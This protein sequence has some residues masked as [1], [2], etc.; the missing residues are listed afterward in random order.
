MLEDRV[1]AASYQNQTNKLLI[2][3]VSNPQLWV[4]KVLCP[5]QTVCFQVNRS[6]RIEIYT[7]SLVT[8]MIE[9]I[10]LAEELPQVVPYPNDSQYRY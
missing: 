2:L 7:Y 1:V 4:E 3:R 9:E 10:I 6:S 8:M 5:G